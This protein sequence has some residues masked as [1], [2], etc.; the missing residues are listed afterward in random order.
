MWLELL[1]QFIEWLAL[2][3]QLIHCLVYLHLNL[4]AHF[5]H[6]PAHH[7]LLH[8][9]RIR[10]LWEP[11]MVAWVVWCLK[12]IYL[13]S[14]I[15]PSGLIASLIVV[16]LQTISQMKNCSL[17]EIAALVADWKLVFITNGWWT[18]CCVFAVHQHCWRL[19]GWAIVNRLSF[20]S[21]ST[22][23]GRCFLSNL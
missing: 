13:H 14:Q 2:I 10:R 19:L 12:S 8:V 5:I 9:L 16:N 23:Y 15:H 22:L 6:C 18:V 21:E 1:L 3:H 17:L 7:F 20:N 11:G 4:V